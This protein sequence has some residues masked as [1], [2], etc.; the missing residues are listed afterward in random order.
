MTIFLL[1][2][3]LVC[4]GSIVSASSILTAATC[5]DSLDLDGDGEADEGTQVVAGTAMLNDMAGSN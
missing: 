2:L 4:G 5:C 3:G 1:F